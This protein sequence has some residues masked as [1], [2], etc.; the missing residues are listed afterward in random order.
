MNR[1]PAILRAVVPFVVTAILAAWLLNRVDVHETMQLLQGVNLGWFAIA[2]LLV[3]IQVV[4]GAERWRCAAEALDLDLPRS[5]AIAE[6]G[7]A[8]LL[9]QLLPG[10]VAGDGVRVWRQQRVDR[11]LGAVVRAAVADRAFGLGVHCLVVLLGVVVW[12]VAHPGIAAPPGAGLVATGLAVAL[13]LAALA[14]AST[15]GW[16]RVASDLRRAVLAR[17]VV[18]GQTLRS[19]LF[20]AAVLLGFAACGRALGLELGAATLTVIPWILL[21]MVLPVSV[22][23]WGPR[24][25]TAVT[26]L[27]LVGFTP[28]AAVAL[29]TVYG[30][31]S[32]AGA[33]P[34]V[35]ALWWPASRREA[36]QL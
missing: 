8:T 12:P 30:L 18:V 32:L 36:L 3:P 11:P 20:T 26:L 16:G 23:G 17:D 29:S 1:A 21:A 28:E 22:G 15:P 7:L 5:E 9:N 19:V 14:P 24:E 2:A 31:S 6:L 10:G 4:L 25:A 27:P 34:G 35:A 13:L 33:L